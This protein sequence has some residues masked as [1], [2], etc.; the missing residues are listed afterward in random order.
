MY[1]ITVEIKENTYI[2]G[3]YRVALFFNLRR[4]VVT[5]NTKENTYIRGC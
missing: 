3:C 1:V 4:H 2:K 5:V